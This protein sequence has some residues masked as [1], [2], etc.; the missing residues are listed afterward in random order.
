MKK[1]K[2]KRH[3]VI[4]VC[5]LD[6]FTRDGLLWLYDRTANEYRCQTPKNTAVMGH[7]YAVETESGEKDYSVETMFSEVEG[8]GISVI[9]KLEQDE[10]IE[11][12]ERVNLSLFLALL[13]NRVPRFEREIDEIADATAKA[14]LKKMIPTVE[15]AAAR[16]AEDPD[17]DRGYSPE[18]FFRFIHEEQYTLEGNRN[19]TV[20]TMLEQA[21]ELARE[22]ALMDWVIAHANDRSAFVATDHRSVIWCQMRSGVAA[23]PCMVSLRTESP[24]L[25][26]SRAE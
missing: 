14:L 26:H 21:P 1:P 17:P 22:L 15:A 8:L 12:E 16:L 23:S 6:G 19:N 5:Y 4:P 25:L 2:P 10:D 20:R 24:K 3:H 13:F 11:P 18:D 7:Y 9:R